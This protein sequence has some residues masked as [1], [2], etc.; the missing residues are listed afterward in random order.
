MLNK[1]WLKNKTEE[2]ECIKPVLK[3]LANDIKGK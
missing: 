3:L 2:T 1:I